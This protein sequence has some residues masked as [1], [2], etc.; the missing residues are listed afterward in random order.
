[1]GVETPL[2]PPTGL[3]E[4]T[5]SLSGISGSISLINSSWKEQLEGG[6]AVDDVVADAGLVETKS[7]RPRGDKR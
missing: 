6:V 2:F 4:P 1:M 3:F 5:N 7:V